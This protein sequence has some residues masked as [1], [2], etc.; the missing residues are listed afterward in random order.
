MAEETRHATVPRIQLVL[1]DA[2]REISRGR[3]TSLW[4]LFLVRLQQLENRR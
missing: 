2:T 1:A 4:L 3:E